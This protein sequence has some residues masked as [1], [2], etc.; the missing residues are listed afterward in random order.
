MRPDT[1]RRGRV[2]QHVFEAC[3]QL[4]DTDDH[5]NLAVE[6]QAWIPALVQHIDEDTQPDHGPLYQ[7]LRQVYTAVHLIQGTLLSAVLRA[8][9]DGLSSDSDSD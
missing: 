6:I 2:L 8:A 4:C 5:R 3:E 1:E 9:S 7:L